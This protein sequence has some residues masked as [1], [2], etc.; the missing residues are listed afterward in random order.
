MK[1]WLPR[2]AVLAAVL[3]T[4]PFSITPTSAAGLN[5]GWS[6]STAIN[7][8]PSSGSSS[9]NKN[10][11]CTSNAGASVLIGSV[12]APAGLSQVVGQSLI[13]DYQLTTSPLTDWWNF[14]TCRSTPSSSVS[15]TM[16]FDPLLD[17]GI[18]N[19]LWVQNASSAFSYQ[20][21]TP[22]PG[23][24]RV[25]MVGAVATSLGGPMAAGTEW[26]SFRLVVDNRHTVTGTLP[27]CSGCTDGAC[28]AFQFCQ[29]NNAVGQGTDANLFT[30]DPNGRQ[31]VTWNIASNPPC[32]G[33]PT[34]RS[35]WGQL[36]SQYR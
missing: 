29:L 18:C 21:D 15:L 26:Y 4:V 33:V 5:L 19:D 25:T 9:A 24:G 14:S 11:L 31:M 7:D 8:C 34:K 12:V 28:F 27:V 3:A 6:S 16:S 2:L 35:T 20:A 36:K 23:Q 10:N 13:V 32:T 22:A 30:N 1:H 17:D